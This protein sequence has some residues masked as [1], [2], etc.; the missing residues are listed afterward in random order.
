MDTLSAATIGLAAVTF[1]LAGAAFFAVW[2]NYDLRKKE[3]VKNHKMVL[4]NEIDTCAQECTQAIIEYEIRFLQ[5]QKEQSKH[6]RQETERLER[7]KKILQFGVELRKQAKEISKIANEKTIILPLLNGVDIYERIR[8]HLDAGIVLQSCVFIGTHIESPGVIYQKG[9]TCKISI[10]ADPE[11][12]DFKLDSLIN[13]LNNAGINFELEENV[14]ISI[15]SKYIFIAA[16]GLV[17]ASFDKTLGEIL[18]NTELS[19]AVKS[20]MYEIEM[21]ARKLLKLSL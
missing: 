7:E 8:E 1:L 3:A 20:I 4:L 6:L 10:G 17:T 18:E 21:I 9:G 14:K 2:Q 15:W 11:F 12:P 13:L 19:Q 16:Y 5:L